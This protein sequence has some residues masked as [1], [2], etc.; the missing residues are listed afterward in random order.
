MILA[1]PTLTLAG[2]LAGVKT[3]FD[4]YTNDDE[5]PNRLVMMQED[6]RGKIKRYEFVCTNKTPENSVHLGIQEVT[7]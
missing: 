6:S 7:P 4:V 1:P 2:S 5:E 3:R